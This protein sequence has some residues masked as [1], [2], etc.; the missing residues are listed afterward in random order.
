MRFKTV[1]FLSFSTILINIFYLSKCVL[2]FITVYLEWKKICLITALL[3]F[4]RW[5]AHF[6]TL[7]R[8]ERPS[9]FFGSACIDAA[10]SL[11]ATSSVRYT[12][13]QIIVR[14]TY[15]ML[16][17]GICAHRQDFWACLGLIFFTS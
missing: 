3:F 8:V 4:F 6:L 9:H 14:H 5:R 1:L 13:P 17:Y 11:Q 16:L 2:H 15:N 7:K 12:P 10:A